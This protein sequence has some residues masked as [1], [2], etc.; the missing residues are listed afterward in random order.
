MVGQHLDG[1]DCVAGCQFP[2]PFLKTA[3]NCHELLVIDLVIALRRRLLLGEEGYRV[4]D[5]IVLLAHDSR[6][7]VVG[8]VGLYD[9]LE[10][11]VKVA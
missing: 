10:I 11:R 6:G 1:V 4:Q 7:Y 5:A 2:A 9:S 3:Y 8:A